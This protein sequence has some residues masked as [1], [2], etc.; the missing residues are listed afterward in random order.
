MYVGIDIGGTKVDFCRF[1]QDYQV[2]AHAKISTDTLQPGSPVFW[3][4]FSEAVS[5]FITQEDQRIGIAMKGIVDEQ[6]I[7]YSSLMGGEVD[8]P[9]A[10]QLEEILKKPVQIDN[11]IRPLARAERHCGQGRGVRS[12]S[13]VNLG[14]GLGI[15]N[16]D[17]DIVKGYKGVAGQVDL[18]TCWVEQ[19]GRFE[20]FQNLISGSGVA[21]L[22][23]EVHGKALSAEEIFSSARRNNS[24][25]QFVV[26][27]CMRSLANFLS[28]LCY[29]YN[30]EVI[31]IHGSM[32]HSLNAI[33]DRL[34]FE[35][36][37]TT[38]VFSRPRAIVFSSL[39]HAACLGA[40]LL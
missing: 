33:S 30:P 27:I 10:T 12:F 3:K 37:Q 40:V 25:A 29:F 36:E 28:S 20:T 35:V 18:L 5:G 4:L 24:A 23:K 11:D 19:L 7:V 38:D 1:N 2:I 32:R 16:V 6:Q 31:I 13:I 26:N 14:T 21:A 8:A 34:F 22:Y 15:V 17:G 9:L 39:E